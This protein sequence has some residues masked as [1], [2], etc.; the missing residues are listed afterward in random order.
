MLLSP[1]LTTFSRKIILLSSVFIL[2]LG[3]ASCEYK[4]H[5]LYQNPTVEGAGEPE[6][7]IVDLNLDQD[8]VYMYADRNVTFRFTSSNQEIQT[9]RFL[10]DGEVKDTVNSNQ[11]EFL[12][13]INDFYSGIHDLSLQVLTGSGTGSI[14]E[15]LGAEGF[16]FENHWVLVVIHNASG[17]YTHTAENGYLRLNFPAMQGHDIKEYVIYR[18]DGNSVSHDI[19][20][21]WTNH[22]IDTCYVG[23]GG[24]Y[25]VHAI[26]N[27]GQDLF[28]GYWMLDPE[29][30][31]LSF[32]ATETNQYFMYW[33][34]SKYYNGIAYIKAY[35]SKT[36][37]GNFDLLHTSYSPNDSIAFLNGYKFGDEFTSKIEL[38]PK[39]YSFTYVPN[40]DEYYSTYDEVMAGYRFANYIYVPNL[41]KTAESNQILFSDERTGLMKY[42]L[43]DLTLRQSILYEHSGCNSYTF[44]DVCVSPFGKFFTAHVCDFDQVYSASTSDITNYRVRSM[45]FLTGQYSPDIPVSDNHIGL[46]NSIIGGVYL[47][48]FDTQSVVAEYAINPTVTS[49][50][51]ISSNAD[52][53]I[54]YEMGIYKLMHYSNHQFTQLQTY[55]PDVYTSFEFSSVANDQFSYW[56]GQFL[57]IIRASD[58]AALSKIDISGERFLAVDYKNHEALTGKGQHLLVRSTDTGELLHDIPINDISIYDYY[59]CSLSDHKILSNKGVLYFL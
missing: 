11:G 9:I 49:G 1:A 14:A 29:L 48:N 4:L 23:E 39:A 16:Y 56:D 8:T 2:F 3:L 50:V 6:V 47:Y 12:L 25:T 42:S 26:L 24:D 30:P 58:Q 17:E 33:S 35:A 22:F 55:D 43:T 13:V 27:S 20:H 7:N 41:I 15:Q 53:M 37:Y 19:G 28:W 46:V 36:F 34:R 52:Y 59:H 21:V 54:I 5:D 31:R 51:C 38:V 10:V 32:S 18:R 44:S 45:S 57:S 40:Y